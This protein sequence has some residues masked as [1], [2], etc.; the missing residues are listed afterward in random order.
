VRRQYFKLVNHKTLLK[1][2]VSERV[3]LN[4]GDTVK[5]GERVETVLTIETK[6]NYEYLLFEDLKPA[7]LEAV[8]LR[9]GDNKTLCVQGNQIQRWRE[10]SPN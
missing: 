8:Q 9:S 1:G 6:N 5:S 2:F 4:D 10:R 3:P 7:G